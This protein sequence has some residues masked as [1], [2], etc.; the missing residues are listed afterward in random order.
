[1]RTF[2]G[3]WIKKRYIK[4]KISNWTEFW[5]RS[6]IICFYLIRIFIAYWDEFS[7]FIKQNPVSEGPFSIWICEIFKSNLLSSNVKR[8]CLA[9]WSEMLYLK[10]SVTFIFNV[11][12]LMR[13]F[14]M[15]IYL[16]IFWKRN[17][18][19]LAK[20]SIWSGIFVL[21]YMKRIFR[22]IWSEIRYRK[23]NFLFN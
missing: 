16:D 2:S 5:I 13:I 12:Y 6:E 11:S 23:R 20:V 3:I 15:H 7:M 9:I 14:V 22:A 19:S 4:W 17:Q 1:M 10:L 18:L 8:I 21:C